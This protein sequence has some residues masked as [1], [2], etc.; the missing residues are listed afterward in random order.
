MHYCIGYLIKFIPGNNFCAMKG[1]LALYSWSAGGGCGV[2]RIPKFT[3]FARNGSPALL[4][5][6]QPVGDNKPITPA[7]TTTVS[8]A[9]DSAGAEN[10]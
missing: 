10:Q 1:S 2:S 5:L 9:G 7:T 8:T 4:C 3:P 6:H